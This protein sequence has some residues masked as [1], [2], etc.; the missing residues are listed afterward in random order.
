MCRVLWDILISLVVENF[1]FYF[2]MHFTSRFKHSFV[3]LNIVH[4]ANIPTRL[5]KRCEM[6]LRF[7]AL[8]ERFHRRWLKPDVFATERHKI[9]DRDQPPMCT[10]KLNEWMIWL[11]FLQPATHFQPQK[12]NLVCLFQILEYSIVSKRTWC[13]E[14]ILF[15]VHMC[16]KFLHYV[17]SKNN[18]RSVYFRFS[19]AYWKYLFSFW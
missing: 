11:S 12:M 19:F 10:I 13:L 16:R 15:F 6:N 5:M 2:E 18:V 7:L 9:T 3:A 1:G 17:L 4:C 14:P 8:G